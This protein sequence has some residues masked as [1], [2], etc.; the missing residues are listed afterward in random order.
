MQCRY[1]SVSPSSLVDNFVPRDGLDPLAVWLGHLNSRL[2]QPIS[3]SILQIN[4]NAVRKFLKKERI[5][6][7]RLAR[8]NDQECRKK[9]KSIQFHIE[10]YAHRLPQARN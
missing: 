1:F 3:L 6:L 5:G 10:K 7:G 4:A 9:E 2:F 8:I